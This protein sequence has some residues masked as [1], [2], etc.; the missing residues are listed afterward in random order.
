MGGSTQCNRASGEPETLYL[1]IVLKDWTEIK[2][3]E[4]SSRED[5]KIEFVEETGCSDAFVKGISIDLKSILSNLI[6]NAVES[7]G[8]HGGTVTIRLSCDTANCSIY[9]IDTGAGIPQEH[10]ADIGKKSI[11]FKGSKSRGLGVTHAFKVI[12][13]WGGQITYSSAVGSGTTVRIDLIKMNGSSL[14]IANE[15]QGDSAWL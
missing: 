6:N 15:Q 10:I 1:P 8:T 2:R 11:S 7:Y 3:L 12:E 9:V 5:I 14:S 13:S 4:L